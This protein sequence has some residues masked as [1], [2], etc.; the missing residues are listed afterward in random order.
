MNNLASRET[1]RQWIS[2][3]LMYQMGA[4]PLPKK[5]HRQ[6]SRYRARCRWDE[7]AYIHT[8]CMNK[9]ASILDV[10]KFAQ[11]EKLTDQRH[12]LHHLL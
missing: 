9:Y 7:S 12:L 11:V 6:S 10:I 8:I 5:H 3:S 1:S 2:K 4:K